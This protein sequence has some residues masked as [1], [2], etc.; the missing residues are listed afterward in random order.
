VAGALLAAA[1]LR[2]DSEVFGRLEQRYQDWIALEADEY[3]FVAPSAVTTPKRGFWS[4]VL[5][6]NA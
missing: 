4:W 1:G 5:R 3:V 2:I 6:R